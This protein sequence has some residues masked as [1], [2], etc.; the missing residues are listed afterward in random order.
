MSLQRLE[1]HQFRNL[2]HLEISL[3]PGLQVI[4][5]D[6]ASGKTS[7]LEAI[8]TLCSGKSF[9]GAVPRKMQQINEVAFSLQGDI[10]Q[11]KHPKQTLHYRWQ[12]HHIH[13][14]VGSE[15]ARR[16]S[17][18]AVI[19]PVQTLSPIS[20]RLIDETPENRR[21]FLDWGVFHVKRGYS[22][23][24]RKF[25]RALTQRNAML[26]VGADAR[27]LNAW[28]H[29]YIKLAEQLDRC[30]LEYIQSLVEALQETA[31]QL[32]PTEEVRLIY[33]PG[34]NRE[35]GLEAQLEANFSKDR[36]RRY[37]YFGPQRADIAIRLN[38]VPARDTASRGQKKLLIFALYL[39]QAM[40]QQKTGYREGLLMIDDLP[41][42]LDKEHLG[43]VL[44]VLTGLPMQV[45]VS[46]IDF[47]QLNMAE[48]M[49]KKRFHVKQGRVTEVV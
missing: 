35:K 45:I 1:V 33:L 34:W 15:S 24:W 29:E 13:L 37:T 40:L 4:S 2:T 41:S 27:A 18:Y 16:A 28:S 30:R 8:H 26:A 44:K 43:L 6:N 39:A 14:K 19:Q 22:S 49:V 12:N 21:R 46:C 42:E 48:N 9:L 32:F 36:E 17:E 47:Q 38:G 20:Y 25:H 7:V 10:F 31:N 23:I 11:P 3:D 5:G